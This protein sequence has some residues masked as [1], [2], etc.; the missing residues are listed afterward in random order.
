MMLRE[1]ATIIQL[2]AAELPLIL[3]ISCRLHPLSENINCAYKQKSPCGVNITWL[4]M[5][6]ITQYVGAE[7][8]FSVIA[9]G[10]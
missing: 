6:G 1:L 10:Y 5:F 8:S 2:C 4:Y 3:T 7:D 9:C